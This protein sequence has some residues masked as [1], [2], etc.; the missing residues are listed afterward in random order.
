VNTDNVTF[1]EE[2]LEAGDIE[3]NLASRILLVAS[4]IVN[5]IEGDNFLILASILGI[6]AGLLTIKSA[7]LEA[8][9]QQIAP[10]VTTFANGLKL[11]GSHISIIVSLILFWALLIEVA[12]RQTTGVAAEP[13]L[14]GSVGAFLV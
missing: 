1:S 4:I 2:Q 3:A 13:T 9:A 6:A 8:V 5:V 12:A 14:A 7:R 10:G 11:I